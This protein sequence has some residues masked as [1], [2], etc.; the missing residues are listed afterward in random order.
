MITPPSPSL[1]ALGLVGQG[2]LLTQEQKRKQKELQ[3]SQPDPLMPGG[4]SG[5][6][7]MDLLPKLNFS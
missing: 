6:S 5:N 3:G 1:Q 7:V 4:L 2:D